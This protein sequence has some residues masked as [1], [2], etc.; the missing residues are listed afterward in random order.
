MWSLIENKSD[1]K[2]ETIC[3]KAGG[4]DWCK[5]SMNPTHDRRESKAIIDVPTE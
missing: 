4:I 3:F 2:A 1:S 5:Y